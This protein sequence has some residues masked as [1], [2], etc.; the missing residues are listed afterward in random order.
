[1]R[2]GEQFTLTWDGVNFDRKRIYLTRTK[3]G[4]DCEIFY[5]QELLGHP[6]GNS[7][8]TPRQWKNL[9]VRKVQAAYYRHEGGFQRS[10]GGSASQ[11]VSLA[12]LHHILVS[13]LIAA[14]VDLPTVHELAGHR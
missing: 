5:E 10:P 2:R 13:R 9:P 14:G 7:S 8:A 11:E 1:M 12:H 3:N 4:S 6:A